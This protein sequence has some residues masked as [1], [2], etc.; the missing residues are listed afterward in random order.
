MA[1]STKSRAPEPARS[2]RK[3]ARR[4]IPKNEE[5]EDMAQDQ[6]TKAQTGLYSL[7]EEILDVILECTGLRTPR[8]AE[9][10]MQVTA[11]ASLSRGLRSAFRNCVSEITLNYPVEQEYDVSL[12]VEY[13]ATFRNLRRLTLIDESKSA[14]FSSGYPA[15]RNSSIDTLIINGQAN[16]SADDFDTLLQMKKL[17]CLKLWNCN[18]TEDW[19]VSLPTKESA[20]YRSRSLRELELRHCAMDQLTVTHRSIGFYHYLT[21][22]LTSL[23][24]LTVR[25]VKRR[26]G[27]GAGHL[28]FMLGG[29]LTTMKNTLREINLTGTDFTFRDVEIEWPQLTHL[30]LSRVNI[31]PMTQPWSRTNSNTPFPQLTHLSVNHALE[32]AA[33]LFCFQRQTLRRLVVLEVIDDGPRDASLAISHINRALSQPVPDDS[34]PRPLRY[35]TLPVPFRDQERETTMLLPF[36]H[37][38]ATLRLTGRADKSVSSFTLEMLR[39]CR[40]ISRLDISYNVGITSNV[41][42]R[43]VRRWA[44]VDFAKRLQVL[45]LASIPITDANMK[46]IVRCCP[47][48]VMLNLNYNTEITVEAVKALSVSDSLMH[49][50]LFRCEFAK[51]TKGRPDEYFRTCRCICGGYFA[52]TDLMPGPYDPCASTSLV[53][54]PLMDQAPNTEEELDYDIHSVHRA[55][56][57]FV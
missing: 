55:M 22:V 48:L 31:M 57:A 11:L 25:A 17:S 8:S 24:K 39:Y 18:S 42:T 47:N 43:I 21:E 3:K 29:L 19:S 37:R 4:T 12:A 32:A 16:F 53:K 6:R 49:V 51:K 5:E 14:D 23:E 56:K 36:Q 9:E 26:R 30:S 54:D 1:V 2:Q 50:L 33:T 38:L 20:A 28:P 13:C 7:P 15:L 27:S 45:N 46:Q 52:L 34:D 10:L 35:L 41:F 40:R 44:E